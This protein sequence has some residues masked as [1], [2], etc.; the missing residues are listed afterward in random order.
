MLTIEFIKPMEKACD[1]ALYSEQAIGCNDTAAGATLNPP[2]PLN[3]DRESGSLTISVEDMLVDIES[4]TG[5]RQVNAPDNAVVAYRF[6][7]RPFTLI[8]QL[9]PVEPIVTVADRVRVRLEET[10]LVVAHRLTLMSK[11]PV[12]TRSN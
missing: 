8:L 4:L 6:N 1:L 2:Q 12:S 7:S 3:V 5:L 9:K 10:R 11:M